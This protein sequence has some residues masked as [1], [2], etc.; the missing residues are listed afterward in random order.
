MVFFISL[1]APE[2][3]VDKR[4]SQLLGE[5]LRPGV[6]LPD[7]RYVIG[8]PDYVGKLVYILF[9]IGIGQNFWVLTKIHKDFFYLRFVIYLV[10][11]GNFRWIKV[12][13]TK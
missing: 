3:P 11:S 5:D 7:I 6:C 8:T 10:N 1:P 2:H 4:I 9:C 12:L 13:L